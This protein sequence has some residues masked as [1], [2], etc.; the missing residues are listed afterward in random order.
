MLL[1]TSVLSAAVVGA[2]GYQSGQS[3]LRASV[4]DRLT[5][6]RAS[7]SRQLAAQFDDLKNS[8]VVYSRGATATQ[9][10]EAFTAGFD[11]LAGATIAP[12]QQ[13]ALVDYYTNRFARDEYAQTGMRVDVASVLPT[14]NAQRYL[15]ANYT[16]PFTD[17]TKAIA[18]ADAGDGSAWS[19]ANARYNDFF[20]QI[21]ERFSYEDALLLDTRGN[22]VYSAY[23][24][25]DLG[26]NILTGPFKGSNL[27]EAYQKALDTNALGYV[28]V[29][30]FSDYEPA[31]EPTAW[32]VSPVGPEG[33]AEGVLALQFPVSK[34]NNLMT[35]DKQWEQAGMG[36]T[37]ETFLVGPD[38]LMRS[39]SRLFLEDPE[40]FKRDVVDAGTPPEVAEDSIREG[41]TTLVQPVATEAT[42]E[43]QRGQTGSLIALDYLGHETLQAYAPVDLPGLNWSI[44]A[45]IDTDEAFAPVSAFTRTLVLSTAGIIFAV[46]VAAMLLAR[47]FVRPIRRLEAGAQ[48]I[49]GGDYTV[50]L[51]VRTRDEFGDLTVA[52]NEMSRNLAIKEDLLEEQRR[53]ND[54]LLLS[55]MPEPVVARYREGEEIIAQ[56]HQDVTVIF[57]DI[58]GLDEL[59]TDMSSDAALAIVNKLMRQ[60]DA[61]AENLGVE[62]VRT[63][64]NGYLASCGLSVP[65]LDNV[66]RTVDFAVEM[67]H[68]V[69]RFAT[70]SGHDLRLRAGIDTG[71]VSSGLVGRTSLAYDMWGAAV[72]VAYRVQSGSAQPGV[73]VTSRVFDAMRDTRR[74]TEAGEVGTDDDAETIWRLVERQQ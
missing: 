3:S 67:Q 40:A 28:G 15:Q 63:L 39:D 47:L 17:W 12:A 58:V 50:S 19:A 5:E 69:D 42:R 60:F 36:A 33:R 48:Q 74:F 65:R 20:R 11:Q 26:T 25:V 27:D 72:N 64:R 61:A 54:R 9:A 51:P 10:L 45:S 55:L 52:F 31:D 16:A 23:R 59:S 1:M 34:I 2:I 57:A 68:I 41:G 37:G 7:Q 38:N 66:R 18:F 24:G 30:D 43:A 73:Y 70:E 29:T 22:V 4:F 32:L 62:R 49:S 6:I 21:V 35:A 46:C 44:L 14:S 13:Q 71:T 56:D 8:L 53:E